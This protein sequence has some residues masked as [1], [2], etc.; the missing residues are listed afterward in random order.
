MFYPTWFL[1]GSSFVDRCREIQE[2]G[3]DGAS[4][5]V[6][7]AEDVPDLHPFWQAALARV[8]DDLAELGLDRSLH[9]V[10]DQY[11]K[12]ATVSA[13]AAMFRGQVEACVTALSRPGLP[14]LTV[15]FHVPLDG[16][17]GYGDQPW[18]SAEYVAEAARLIASLQDAYGVRA[19]IE[20]VFYPVIG[21]P[22]A[23]GRVL[24]QY[25]DSVGLLLDTGHAHMSLR[26]GWCPHGSLAELVRA[27]PSPVVEVH[28]HDN[29][30]E[31]DQHLP[32]GEG[33]A[34]L[35]GLFEG[36]FETGF[37]GPVTVECAL[38]GEGR[39]GLAAG[40]ARIRDE[41]GL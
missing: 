39:P 22:E 35:H 14:P 40:L 18:L 21:T 28:L 17:Q 38:K 2:A 20:N 10:T 19:G 31:R 23:L 7:V 27:L 36:L 25:P 24:A 13:G 9:V 16:P 12:A 34:D 4:F 26:Y 30:G 3:F 5:A 1:P 6:G 15:T 37:D 29:D 33:T 32:P 11:Q 8:G 41:Y